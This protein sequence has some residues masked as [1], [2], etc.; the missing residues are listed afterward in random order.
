[1]R[2]ASTFLEVDVLAAAQSGKMVNG[3]AWSLGGAL[4]ILLAIY[5]ADFVAKEKS[6][7]SQV[8]TKANQGHVV[9]NID[10][11][12]SL[13]GRVHVAFCQS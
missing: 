3:S 6:E 11:G 8:D 1:M 9:D 12:R 5:A 2:E 13:G 4:V 10:Q 7:T